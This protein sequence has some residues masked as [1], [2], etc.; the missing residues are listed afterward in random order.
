MFTRL[1]FDLPMSRALAVMR[2]ARNMFCGV[3]CGWKALVCLLDCLRR[4]LVAFFER[5]C[6]SFL[7]NSLE[8]E[9]CFARWA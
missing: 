1:V 3:A 8:V 9:M 5:V 7:R 2:R 6:V 4:F